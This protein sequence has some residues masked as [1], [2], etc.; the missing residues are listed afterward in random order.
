MRSFRRLGVCAGVLAIAV[1]APLPARGADVRSP[2][3]YAGLDGCLCA[4]WKLWGRGGDVVDLTDARVF[5]SRGRRAPLALSPNGRHVAYFHLGSG[6]LTVRKVISGA[7]RAV[8]GV[9][10]SSAMRAT[11]IDLSPRGRYAVLGTGGEYRILDTRSGT[12]LTLR[13]GLRPWSFSP[14][15]EFVL[16]VDDAFQAK[17]YSMSPFAER[18]RVPVGGALG[19][20]GE[21]VAHFTEG[22]A[23]IGLWSVPS[24]APAT[25]VPVA[26]PYGRTPTRL[27][28]NVAGLLDLQTVVSRRARKG[29]GNRYG[30]YRVDRETGGTER[31]AGFVVPGSVH[32]PIVAGLSP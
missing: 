20:G 26:V 6:A 5:S 14:D 1:G 25:G 13:P 22:D 17:V 28:W 21:T 11:R 4:P 27:R 30:W 12:G 9:T 7:V 19:P 24:G 18:G 16:V 3:R 2:A 31:I 10:W 29:G 23:G 8:P 32:H 15:A